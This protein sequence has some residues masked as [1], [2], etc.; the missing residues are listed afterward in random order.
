MK[1]KEWVLGIDLGTSSVKVVALDILGKPL[2]FDSEMYL[3]A[4]GDRPWKEQDINLI[5]QAMCSAVRR[6]IRDS[7]MASSHC[8][9]LSIGGALHGIMAVDQEINPLTY[10]MSWADSRATKI[11]EEIRR[12]TDWFRVYRLTGCPPNGMYS[13]YKIIWL[14]DQQ[15]DIFQRAQYFVSAKAYILQK[16]TGDV[17]IDHAVA[18]GSGYYDIGKH[19][20]ELEQLDRAGVNESQLPE[21][22]SPWMVIDGIKKDVA[23]DLNLP[24]SIKLVVGVSDA[25]NSTIGAGSVRSDQFTCMI[26]SSG[27]IRHITDTQII[28]QEARTWCYCVDAHKYLVGG[29]INNGGIVLNWLADNLMSYSGREDPSKFDVSTID[30]L[31]NTAPP[32]A[33]GLLFLPFL[34][35]E[36]SPGWNLAARGAIFGLGLGHDVSH[37]ARA[38]LEGVA[39][40]MKSVQDALIEQG[41]DI[42]EIRASGGF[43]KSDLWTKIIASVLGKTI[44]V[45]PW[46]DTSAIGAGL[47]ALSGI[48]G[49]TEIE[50]LQG[51]V[52]IEKEVHP[53]EELVE[54]YAG[55]YS[56]YSKM[57]QAVDDYSQDIR[58]LGEYH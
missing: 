19:Q 50:L 34:A 3:T 44:G 39:F 16:I 40:R 25:V 8:L 46:P 18:S 48:Q 17:I 13:Y 26:G 53:E 7:G 49:Q 42:S 38:A 9:S 6:L 45:T 43:T 33:M 35:G 2:G 24:T 41:A 36:R 27:A 56:L 47:F 31:A 21:L 14:K 15:S 10:L 37:I 55:I 32:G 29:A 12:E 58:R 22:V 30:H 4:E 54:F 52:S 1:K 20:W 23:D 5:Y 51:Y 57:K 28:D 11:A